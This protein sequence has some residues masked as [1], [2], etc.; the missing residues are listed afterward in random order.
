ME[1]VGVLLVSYGSR[2]A[3]IA[4]S[5]CRSENYEV[6]IFDSNKQKNPFIVE[7]AADYEIGLDVQKICKFAKKH[8]DEIDFGIVGPEGQIIGGI[9]DIIEKETRIPMICPTKE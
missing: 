2:E 4:D 7:R 1:K 5:L 3:A 8:E 9:R 6:T